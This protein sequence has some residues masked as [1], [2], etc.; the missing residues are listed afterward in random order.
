MKPAAAWLQAEPSV[1]KMLTA[2]TPG[3]SDCLTLGQGECVA[4]S[5][6]LTVM[7]L[8]CQVSTLI[9]LSLAAIPN[10]REEVFS[11]AVSNIEGV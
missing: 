5:L 8:L 9:S 3:S 7:L 4:I 6:C 1:T 11:V 10:G 2:G